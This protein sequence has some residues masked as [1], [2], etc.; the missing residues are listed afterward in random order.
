MGRRAGHPGGFDRAFLPGFA[1]QKRE[2]SL[3]WDKLLTGKSA[4]IIFTLDQPAWYYRIINGRPGYYAVKKMTLEFCGIR[5]VRTTTIGPIRLSKDSY[6]A[7]L[8]ENSGKTGVEETVDF[9]TGR[10]CDWETVEFSNIP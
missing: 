1:F 5:P 3:W 4:R 2:N 8:A 7:E 6:R 10:L 9:V